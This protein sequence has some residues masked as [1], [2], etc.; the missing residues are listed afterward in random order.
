MIDITKVRKDDAV[1]LADGRD[2]HVKNVYLSP[3]GIMMVVKT[4]IAGPCDQNV[5]IEQVTD[6]KPKKEKG[7]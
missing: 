7:V 5:P 4:G 2:G 6:H 3:T 1:K